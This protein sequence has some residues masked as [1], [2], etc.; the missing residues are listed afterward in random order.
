MKIMKGRQ[1]A[2]RHHE[3]SCIEGLLIPPH[4]KSHRGGD[5]EWGPGVFGWTTVGVVLLDP[6]RG[7]PQI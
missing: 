3:S 6:P 2:K 5:E 1:N 4:T 7:G